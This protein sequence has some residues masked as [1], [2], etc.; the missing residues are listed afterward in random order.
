[1][2]TPIADFV[3]KYAES[4]CVRLHMPGHKGKGALG[5]ESLDI[6]EISG[7]DSLFEANG[8]IAESEK[9]A[10]ALFGANSFY[11]TEGSSLSIR[12]ALYLFML[13]A[14]KSEKKPL[15]L[16]GRNAHKVFIS[17]SVLLDFEFEW[18]APSKNSYLS[19]DISESELSEKLAIYS[20]RCVAVY[21]TSPDYLGRIA[22]I[23]RISSICKTHNAVLIVD[24]AHGAYLKFLSES[25]HPIDLG[26][27]ISLDSAHKTLTVLTG[28][29]YLH[30]SKNT[31]DIFAENAKLALSL[32]GST[33]PSYLILQSLD[34]ANRYIS[35]G[36]KERLNEFCNAVDNLKHEL[37]SKG[38]S[39]FGDEPLKITLDAK[40]YGYYGQELADLIAEKGVVC[41]FADKD[42]VVFMLTPENGL[43]SLE[44]LKDSLFSLP[45]KAEITDSAPE[46]KQAKRALTPKYAM[47][48]ESETVDTENSEGRI[49]CEFN[50]ACPPA[51]PIAVCGEIID[52][53]TIERFEYYGIKKCRVVKNKPL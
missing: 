4:D 34:I 51:V 43:G 47:L 40:K 20:D 1:M 52:R 15:V 17:A 30:I 45:K 32:F 50:V 48:C 28:G 53:N 7:A 3:K 38:F 5:I 26:A 12:A 10:G 37:I 39:L 8:I 46:Y 33:S 31:P 16:A 21:V 29:A 19:C 44:R 27:D 35:N 9:N 13:H 36:F 24:N 6:T 18:L 2:N 25:R 49:L 42:A 11:S 41:E 22:D 14:A 23:K